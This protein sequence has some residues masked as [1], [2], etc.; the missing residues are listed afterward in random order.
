[1][2][3]P[4]QV[5]KAERSASRAPPA[6]RRLPGSQGSP[7]SLLPSV[8]VLV[9][10]VLLDTLLPAIEV[11]FLW[12][13]G[14]RHSVSPLSFPLAP[15]ASGQTNSETARPWPG[16]GLSMKSLT[17]NSGFPKAPLLASGGG[18]RCRLWCLDPWPSLSHGGD[19][20]RA[21]CV[22]PRARSSPVGRDGSVEERA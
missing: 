20:L 7:A 10:L 6:G 17:W 5:R 14:R 12:Q 13:V 19:V 18:L 15:S 8:L 21:C 11:A 4:A 9:L 2:V 3:L 22:T 1:M 16:K